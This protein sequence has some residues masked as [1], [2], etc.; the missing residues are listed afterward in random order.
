MHIETIRSAEEWAALSS[1]WNQL[2]QQ[3]HNNVPFLTYEFQRAWWQHLGG[4]EWPEAELNILV[5][6]GDDGALR[7]IAPLFRTM[8]NRKAV[9]QFIGSHEIADFLDLIARPQDLATFAA[10]VMQHLKK[11]ETWS[12]VALYNLLDSSATMAALQ[13]AAEG[14]G[15]QFALETLQ[16]SP[17]IKLPASYEDYLASLDSKQAH[18][19]R[20]KQ[21]KAER[22]GKQISIETVVDAEDL[23][24]ALV[25]F[26]NLMGQE[27]DKDRFLSAAMR[28]QMEAIA[29]AAFAAGWLQLFFLKAGETRVAG[30]M[31]F[32]YENRI[33]GYNAGFDNAYAEL[34]PGWLVMGEMI[35]WCI[36]HGRAVF[37]FMRGG[38]EYKYRFG[39]VDRFVQKVTISR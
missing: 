21:R 16:P 2:L 26:F 24:A 22:S 13:A 27:A 32:D 33:W 25:D 12:E 15:L 35:R 20:R 31:N 11:D 5:G 8:Q 23:D 28:A 29:R 18:E 38:E 1:N 4:G 34:S 9:L 7:G 36:E 3:S 19:L 17:Y 37:D 30:Y 39:G 6:R 14:A 10:A